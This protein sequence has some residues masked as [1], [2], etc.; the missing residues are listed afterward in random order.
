MA[1]LIAISSLS[2][3]MSCLLQL[4]IK[5]EIVVMLEKICYVLFSLCKNATAII[6]LYTLNERSSLCVIK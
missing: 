6:T 5:S 2:S 1:I 4:T 3:N